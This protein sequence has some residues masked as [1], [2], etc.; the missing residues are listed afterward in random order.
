MGCMPRHGPLTR[1][2]VRLPI[3]PL[4]RSAC[5]GSR[6]RTRRCLGPLLCQLGYACVLVPRG[7]V[8]PPCLQETPEFEAGA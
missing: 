1:C 8:E 7:G 5:D 3:P 6:T 4:S 2:R